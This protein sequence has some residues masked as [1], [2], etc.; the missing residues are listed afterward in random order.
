MEAGERCRKSGPQ[1]GEI[2][3]VVVRI[4]YRFRSTSDENLPH[5][6][7]LR[8]GCMIAS[9]L[10]VKKEILGNGRL[11]GVDSLRARDRGICVVKQS[12]SICQEQGC[13]KTA[14][15]RWEGTQ[16]RETTSSSARLAV[17]RSELM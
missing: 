16:G 12:S 5:Y 17:S 2:S 1:K 8:H 11:V 15:F 14:L 4:A 6:R 13:V 9:V 3:A 10:E 7:E